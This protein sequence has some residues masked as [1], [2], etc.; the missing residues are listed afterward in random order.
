MGVE[1]LVEEDGKGEADKEE[2]IE[3]TNKDENNPSAPAL[4][5]IL[6]ILPLRRVDVDEPGKE[7]EG[8]ERTSSHLLVELNSNQISMK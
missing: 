6:E 5:S 8:Q 4:R 3:A 7:Q 2:S 1:L